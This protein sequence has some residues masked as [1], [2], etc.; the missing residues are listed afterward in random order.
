MRHDQMF[1]IFEAI[2][3]LKAKLYEMEVQKRKD[4][5]QALEDTKMD[6]SWGSQIRSYVL[7]SARI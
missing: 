7:D 1:V 5:A 4:E 2:K 6:I 3:Q